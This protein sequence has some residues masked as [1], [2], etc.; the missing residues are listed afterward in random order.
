MSP[1]AI[2]RLV[3]LGSCL[4]IVFEV[5]L[6]ASCNLFWME[7]AGMLRSYSALPFNE[8]KTSTTSAM[9]LRET[10]MANPLQ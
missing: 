10:T 4:L 9:R 8:V 7:F 6:P 2:I 1:W 3:T 5:K